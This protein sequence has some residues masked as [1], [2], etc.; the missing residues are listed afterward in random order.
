VT[1]T[2]VQIS[3]GGR[4]TVVVKNDYG[5][6]TSDPILLIV[7]VPAQPPGDN[8]ADR[9]LITGFTNSISG[10]N[11]FATR[12]PGEPY[13]A[14]KFGSNSVWYTWQAPTNGIATFRTPGSTFDTLLAVY[15]GTT[16]TNLTTIAADEDLGGYFTSEVRFNA[17]AGTFYHIAIDGFAGASGDFILS[18][19]LEVTSETVPEITK[20]PTSRAVK[21]N[22][23]TTFT[24][25]AS[26]Q[27]LT[28]QWLFNGAVISGATN[29]DLTRAGIQSAS[30]G[31]YTVRVSNNFGRNVESVPATLEIGPV[32]NVFSQDK[33]EDL[34]LETGAG[35]GALRQ[36]IQLQDAPG[37][38]G[39]ILVSAGTPGSQLLNN[40]DATTSAGEPALCGVIGG[41]SKWMRLTTTEEGMFQIDTI[42][43]GI[44]TVLG[45]YRANYLNPYESLVACD[46]DSAPDGTNSWVRFE[47]TANTEYWVVVDGVNAA[48]GLIQ[49]NWRL[50]WPPVITLA[51]TNYWLR[52]GESVTLRVGATNTVGAISYQWLRN[53]IAI[54]GATNDTL[55]LTNIQVGE[56]GSYSVV[57]SNPFGE[58]TSTASVAV[59]VPMLRAESRITGGLFRLW[60]PDLQRSSFF[61]DNLLSQGIMVEAS[62]DLVN[63][64]QVHLHTPANGEEHLDIPATNQFRLFFR[65]RPWP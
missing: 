38:G 15:T 25:A 50:G 20:Q 65:A 10:T 9:V 29:T 59:E 60:L 34:F 46:N 18:W 58:V 43:S 56:A 3:D 23:P 2:N 37:S 57:V 52:E 39:F 28:Y 44:D 32:A 45:V 14:G 12:E 51:L 27:G 64:W 6:A 61:P 13:H 4:Y 16:F 47:G 36:G 21:L 8:F 54:P 48:Q 31:R 30:V 7:E 17:V 5:I 53:N 11:R 63:W 40:T 1:I 33:L 49:L 19:N 55:T 26:G 41:A 24:V 62:E 35:A 42:G 22:D